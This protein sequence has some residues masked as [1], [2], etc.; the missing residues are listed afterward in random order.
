MFVAKSH[1]GKEPCGGTVG[2]SWAA[3]AEAD[4]ALSHWLAFGE[5]PYAAPEPNFD[6]RIEF[7]LRQDYDWP[8]LCT[9]AAHEIGHL[10]GHDHADDDAHLMAEAYTRPL[11]A[12]REAAVRA[13]YV[14]ERPA[15]RTRR[16][17]LARKRRAA[18][19]A[20][21]QRRQAQAQALR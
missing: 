6:C 13:G 19:L 18:R 16:A 21:I 14:A 9:V 3:L 10:L 11:P 5:D 15:Q 20:R 4:A 7:N 1:W 17:R 12:R 2:V 8:K